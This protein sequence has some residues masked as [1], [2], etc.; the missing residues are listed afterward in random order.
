MAEGGNR[1]LIGQGAEPTREDAVELANEIRLPV[2]E[3]VE[4]E[5]A[6]R[7]VIHSFWIPSLGGK[8]DMIPGRTTRLRLEPTRTGVFRG[9]CAEFC[10]ASHA[11]MSFAVVVMEKEEF[12]AWLAGQRAPARRGHEA[13]AARGE[14]LFQANGCGACHS[15]RGTSAR[16]VIA[17]DLTHL[18]SRETLGA[19]VLPNEAA[20][21][22]RWIAHPSALKPGVRMPAFGMLPKDDLRA[23]AA[24][25]EALE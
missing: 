18:G 4:F 15:V 6:T 16:G 10:G 7:D 14:A 19:G 22:E 13:L 24:Y 3:P 11:Y 25:L 8:M 5:L 9:T 2:G 20:A 1:Q 21:L 17:P 23:L 12:A